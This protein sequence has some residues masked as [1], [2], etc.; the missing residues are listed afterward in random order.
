MSDDK[1]N[2]WTNYETWRV[3]LEMVD[4]MQFRRGD[5]RTVAELAEYLNELC[6]EIIEN[7]STP[8]FAR[9]YAMAFLSA[10]NWHEIAKHIWDDN[11]LGS[12]EASE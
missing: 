5:Y 9:D 10:V 8:G 12:S 1:Y 3:N 7:G 6:E 4:G 2:G 11:D